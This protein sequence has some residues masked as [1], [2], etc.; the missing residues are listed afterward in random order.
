MGVVGATVVATA[1]VTAVPAQA[2]EVYP[3]P[4]DN[5]VILSGHGYGHGHGMS[6]WGAYGAAKVG[7]LA[8]PKILAFYYPGTTLTKFA[9]TNIRVR[10][11]AVGNAPLQ[12]PNAAGLQLTTPG[13]TATPLPQVTTAG[14]PITRYRVVPRADGRLQVDQ[15]SAAILGAPAAWTL[16]AYSA[17]PAVFS[18]P[19]R[20][21]LVDVRLKNGSSQRTYRGAM[22]AHWRTAT[23]LTAV[24]VL[25]IESYLRAVVPAEMPSSWHPNAL[26]AQAVAA[27]SYASRNR[28]DAPSGRVHDTC[29]T[30][31]C[32]M[33]SG[34]PAEA[35]TTDAA[36]AATSGQ[37]LTYQGVPAFTQFA[38]SNGG[39]SSSGG[40]PYLV[41][42]ADPYDGAIPNGS[43]SW[44]KAITAVTIEAKWP[45]IGSY[46]RL[47]ISS[48]DGNGQWG[49]RVLQVAVEGSTGTISVAGTAFRTAFG[50]KS[51]WFVPTNLRSAPSYPRDFTRDKKADVLAVVDRTGYLR[52][53]PG[54]GASGWGTMKVV[55]TGFRGYAKVFTAGTW[56]IDGISDVLAQKADGTLWLHPGT[57]AGP[58]GAPRKVGSGWG[59]YNLV[60][61]V[62][63]FSGDGLTDLLA[64]RSDGRLMLFS[65]NGSGGFRGARLLGPG[66]GVFTALFSP[67]DLDG[68]AKS[69]VIVR[70][71]DGSA[72]LYPGNG[73]GG[74]LPRRAIG[75]GWNTYSALL[76]P[77]DLSGNG[78][79]DVLARGFDGRLWLHPGD[80][81]GGLLPRQLVGSGW[82]IFSTVLP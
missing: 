69:D 9:N 27:R 17:S 34:L 15:Y 56:D 6:Q 16:Y 62:G 19:S 79:S 51:E 42:R 11:D 68:D 1:M 52:M 33:Y 50:L 31:W 75:T 59:S 54:N 40:K 82:N 2:D 24:S 48:R 37:T 64:R 55:G 58:L 30:T 78:R 3:R 10:L 22:F 8:W 61:P 7:N 28:A 70:A 77:G 74:F 76:S 13:G 45:S 36:I 20:G 26:A 14:T 12:L 63:D 39:W 67:G 44:T 38:A 73:S 65:G 21:A 60:I 4:W 41:A 80:G 66:W 23:T 57:A 35:A 53:Y 49:G 25:P 71:S 43:N 81:V 29:D 72:Y 18:N 32:Q 47:R 5:T 46:R